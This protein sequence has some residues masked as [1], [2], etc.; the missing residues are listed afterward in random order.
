MIIVAACAL[1]VIAALG[2]RARLAACLWAGF[3]AFMAIELS[4]HMY[5]GY[6]KV[7][8][9]PAHFAV[10]GAGALG[11]IL[12]ASMHDQVAVAVANGPAWNADDLVGSLRSLR[13]KHSVAAYLLAGAIS[14]IASEFVI[15]AMFLLRPFRDDLTNYAILGAAMLGVV[16]GVLIA[17]YG[18]RVALS[19]IALRGSEA[20]SVA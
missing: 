9:G 4:T 15:R 2:L 10:M 20:R 17:R 13:R 18:S 14:F 19:G 8:G 7:Q 6:D 3:A 16:F 1:G 5:F 12:A 11:A